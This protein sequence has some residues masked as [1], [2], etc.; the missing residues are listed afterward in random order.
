MMSRLMLV[1]GVAPILA[2]TIGGAGPGVRPLAGDLLSCS[3]STARSACLLAWRCC[4]RRCRRSGASACVSAGRSARY[5]QDPARDEA[6]DPR[7]SWAAAARS[8]C[9]PIS[10]AASPVFE[11]GFGLSPSEFALIFGA[12]RSAWSSARSSMPGCCRGS[13]RR[14]CW[15]WRARF[16]VRRTPCCCGVAFSGVHVLALVAWRRW[17]CR[18]VARASTTPTR[19]RA[20]CRATPAHAGSASALMGTCQ[21]S[22]GRGRGLL[23]GLLTDGGTARRWRLLMCAGSLGSVIAE[24]FRPRQ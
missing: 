21:F 22:L 7:R 4:R 23:V 5:V 11:D 16:A 6:S 2:P 24:R 15:R 13:A 1:M 10:A 18:S 8:A 17:W 3:R 20:R 9:S 14:G 19:R 12:A